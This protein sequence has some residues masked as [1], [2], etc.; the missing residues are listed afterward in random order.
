M[1][2]IADRLK[3]LIKDVPDFPKE[4]V[5]FKDLT[6]I[7][8]DPDANRAVTTA[9]S[10]RYETLDI[11]AIVAIES[12]GFLLGAPIAVQLGVPL[13]LVRKPGKLPRPTVTRSYALEYGQD[14]LEMH[15]DAVRPGQ[16]VVV[17]D[18]LLATG[19]TANA[20]VELVK[21]V[22][23]EVIEAAFLVE[24]GFLKGRGQ[25]SV[26]VHALVQY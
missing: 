4:G 3:R 23:A 2:G 13:A 14:T 15:V 12:R 22:G 7:F 18:D 16:R 19:G 9:F 11:D 24:L 25:L 8:L 20:T 26:D 1:D 21:E 10:R 17:V 5:I 6:P